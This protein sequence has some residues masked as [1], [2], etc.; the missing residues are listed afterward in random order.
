MNSPVLK[1]ES[2]TISFI[3]K[4]LFHLTDILYF[5][6]AFFTFVCFQISTHNRVYNKL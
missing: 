5:L 6:A 3:L 4:K 1:N 2:V